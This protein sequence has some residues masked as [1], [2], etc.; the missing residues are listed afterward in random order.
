MEQIVYSAS[1]FVIKKPDYMLSFASINEEMQ[2][3]LLLKFVN[4]YLNQ[5]YMWEDAVFVHLFEKYF[6]GKDYPWLTEKG[7]KIISDRAYSLMPN[8]M[9][10]PA[11]DVE[12]PDTAG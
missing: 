12:L 3:F 6:S 2:K 7:K 9:G 1:D 10:T 11:A 5:K 8:I 4:R